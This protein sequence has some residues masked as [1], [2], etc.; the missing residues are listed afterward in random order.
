[1][2]EKMP[3]KPSQKRPPS[4]K[5]LSQQFSSRV[6]VIAALLVIVF[7][8]C[9][10]RL[11]WIQIFSAA[12]VAQA[13]VDSRTVSQTIPAMRGSI[14]DDTGEILAQNVERYTIFADQQMAA[15]F[16]P[17]DCDGTND[18]V[19][20]QVDGKPVGQ[21]GPAAV[22]QILAPVLGMDPLELGAKLV[23]DNAYVVLKKNVVPELK[24]NIDKLNLQSVIGSELTQQRNYPNPTLLG[25]LLGAVNSS[26]KGVAGIEQ[27][28]NTALTG[29]DGEQV[30][31]QGG[32]GQIIPGTQQTK[33]EA[34]NGSTV[35]L[36]IDTDVQWYANQALLQGQKKY[37]ADWGIA[38]V[39]DVKT[40][41]IIAATDTDQ[42][43]AGS[44]QVA[45]NGYSRVMDDVFEPGSTGKLITA[46]ALLQEQIHKPT[47]HFEVPYALTYQK[48]DYHDSE[49]HGVEKLTLAGIIKNSSNVGMIMA[50][51]N[52]GDQKTK[53]LSDQ[54]RYDYI[55]K[56]GLGQPTGINFPGES[57][58]L[59]TP[60]QKW[61][62]RTRQTVLFGQG[63][64]ANAIQM[65]NVVATV[66]NGGVKNA[67]SI[68]AS[69]TDANGT[70]TP[71]A[72]A[73]AERV[74][75]KTVSAQLMD[76]MESV[77]DLYSK[78]IHVDGY[79]IAGKSG[80]AQAADANGGMT[81]IVAD[82]IGVIPA[83]SP[84]FVVMVAFRNPY[85]I[86]GGDTAG[87]VMASIGG[88]L[89][90]KYKV[91]VSQPRKNPIP[92]TW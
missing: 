53:V 41:N 68:I 30:Y 84:R 18:S 6:K 75:D 90:Q 54:M 87:P 56:F 78:E 46:A 26:N 7:L 92:T 25:G 89:M 11:A 32:G 62:G 64:A 28:E 67:P 14:V 73:P 10:V 21:K 5:Q 36:T 58:G 65:T 47:D 2:S 52:L 40:G 23:G 3:Q 12:P 80:T 51:N 37:G 81:N 79:R 55:T 57:P 29:Q 82:W 27:M 34:R 42:A 60:W 13:A 72:K 49:T 19:C 1:M 91:P 69:V 66:A 38:V 48:Q 63:Y 33:T 86:Y 31:Q 85:P 61:D 22:A 45:A 16:V 44:S 8:I 20:N 39:E 71:E 43:S 83:D 9:F 50:S 59:L 76:M 17:V 15:G 74:I 88:F 24:R 70:L 4:A 77:T 35:K